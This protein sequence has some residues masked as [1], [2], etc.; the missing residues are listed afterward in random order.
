MKPFVSLLVLGG[1]MALAAVG[2]SESEPS[3]DGGSS[4]GGQAGTA[5]AGK[6][7]AA[8][9]GS[10]TSGSAGA[11]GGGSGT[12]GVANGGAGGSSGSGSGAGGSNASGAGG[13]MGGTGGSAGAET[14]G[15][16]GSGDGGTTGNEAGAGGSSGEAGGSSGG[17]A[18]G[19]SAGATAGGG[20]DV[21]GIDQLYPSAASGAEWTS[22]HWDGGEAYSITSREDENDPL[23]ISGMRGTGTLEVTG[24]GELVMGGS[25]PRIYIYPSDAGPW[26]NLEITA[27]YQRV[28]DSATAYAGLVIGARSGPDGH[29]SGTECDAHT[30]YARVRNDGAFDFEKELEHPASA[31]QSRVDPETAWPPDGEVPFDT[32][33]GFKFVIYNLEGGSVKLE[34]YRDM[35]NGENGGT[36]EKVNETVDDGGWSVETTC[37]EHSPSG[38]ESDLIVTEGGTTFIR[39]TEVT[40]ARYRW[41]TVREIMAP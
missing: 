11:A 16:S 17:G 19:G 28:E 34:A 27:Y 40:E 41:V 9:G 14:G 32:W 36:W 12:S 39:N 6:G 37:A 24:D 30:Y 10:G 7:G 22:A 4:G 8:N 5:T 29:S 25:Q 26:Q 18:S 23:G 38:G 2:C 1:G 33:I 15:S 21:F 31:T 13:A 20:V 3:G 35:T